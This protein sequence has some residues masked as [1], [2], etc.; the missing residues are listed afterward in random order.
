M[1]KTKRDNS[2]KKGWKKPG[3]YEMLP[4]F[5]EKLVKVE[6]GKAYIDE[7]GIKRKHPNLYVVKQIEVYGS[8]TEKQIHFL[9]PNFGHWR[10]IWVDANEDKK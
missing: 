2:W 3:G 4:S 8:L 1:S 6:E 10:T 5:Y 7:N 9:D